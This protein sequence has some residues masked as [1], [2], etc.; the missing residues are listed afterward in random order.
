M[1][2]QAEEEKQAALHTLADHLKQTVQSVVGS[3]AGAANHLQTNAQHLMDNAGKT[4]RQAKT[5][6]EASEQSA[7]FYGRQ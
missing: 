6:S 7:G 2:R 3:V 4:T 5:V 1:E